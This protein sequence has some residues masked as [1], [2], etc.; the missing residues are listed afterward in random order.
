MNTVSHNAEARSAA[1]IKINSKFADHDY[2]LSLCPFNGY[3]RCFDE[4]KESGAKTLVHIPPREVSLQEGV[5]GLPSFS[6]LMASA[7]GG[8]DLILR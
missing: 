6:L 7:T 2:R 4:S 8:F 5:S 3:S 1:E